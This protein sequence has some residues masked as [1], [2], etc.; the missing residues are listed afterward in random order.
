ML[1]AEPCSETPGLEKS[2]TQK[3]EA[4]RTAALILQVLKTWRYHLKSW[5][6]C[7]RVSSCTFAHCFEHKTSLPVELS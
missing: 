6:E 3:M 1:D 4:G 5:S 2:H 7:S